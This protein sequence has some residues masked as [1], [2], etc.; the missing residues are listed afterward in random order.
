MELRWWTRGVEVGTLWRG[1]RDRQ[2]NPAPSY[3]DSANIILCSSGHSDMI[4]M[5]RMS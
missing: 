4:S 5:L 2:D 3:P 1:G